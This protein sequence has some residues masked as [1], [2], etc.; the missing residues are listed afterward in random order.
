M[1]QS[2]QVQPTS[3]LYTLKQSA[4][5]RRVRITVRPGGEVVLTVPRGVRQGWA[6]QFL[7]QK[8]SWVMKA[9]KNAA[10]FANASSLRG[11][12]KEYREKKDEALGLVRDKLAHVNQHYHFT[13][14]RISIRNQ[15]TRW[16]S[17]SKRG[18]LNFNY[19]ILYLS[20]AAQDYLIVHELCH[21]KEFNH[22]KNFWLLVAQTCPDYR[23][24]KKELR[25]GTIS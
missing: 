25:Y 16:G 15:K 1:E 23:I 13:H 4:R 10:R 2:V 5:A 8:L 20:P 3:F 14:G 22:S 12:K 21:T 24:I 9:Q 17:C 11:S 6:E 19:K 7:R 18:N